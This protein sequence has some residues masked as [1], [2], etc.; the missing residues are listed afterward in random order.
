MIRC[1]PERNPKQ[2]LFLVVVCALIALACGIFCAKSSVYNWI[3]QL[4][5]MGAVSV[6][7][8]AVYRYTMTEMVYTLGG[9]VFEV[10]KI[11]GKKHTTVCSLNIA[12]AKDLVIKS[13]YKYNLDAKK[14][15]TVQK[16]LNFR[17]NLHPAVSYV[18]VSEFNGKTISVEF[19]PNEI[20]VRAFLDEIDRNNGEQ[21]PAT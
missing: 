21:N 13:A 7:V 4:A 19:E 2:A 17:Q 10:V 15:G 6:G 12:T 9:G 11:V 8:F 18:Y 16:Y 20:F 14:Y 1:K 5:F 3:A